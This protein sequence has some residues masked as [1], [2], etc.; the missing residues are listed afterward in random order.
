M[1]RVRE[2]LQAA[3]AYKR[4]ITGA[5]VGVAVLDSGITASH[6][7]LRGRVAL[8]KSF[9]SQTELSDVCG[10]G[11][12]ISGI[13]GGNGTASG[14]RYQGLAPGCHFISLKVLDHR[15]NGRT[16]DLVKAL[17]WLTEEGKDYQVRIVNISMGGTMQGTEAQELL[18]AVEEAWGAGFVVCAAAGNQGPG[19]QSITVPGTSRK[20]ITVGSSDDQEPVQMDG[21]RKTDYSGRGPTRTCICKPDVVAPGSYVVSCNARWNRRGGGSYCTK[22]GTSMATPVVCGALALLLEQRP[23]L[24]NKEVKLRLS[25]TCRDLGLPRNQQG[26]GKIYI[27]SLLG[28]D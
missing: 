16:G 9:C 14:G 12:H 1:N 23:L 4:G 21:K 8:E 20:I 2:Q 25:G 22:S 13:I 27:P 7:D 10:H 11:T 28:E 3:Y 26:W 6:P 17:Y 15:G 24:T 18:R 5:G 19:R